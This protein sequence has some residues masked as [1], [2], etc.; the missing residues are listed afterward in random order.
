MPSIGQPHLRCA[1]QMVGGCS[2][3]FLCLGAAFLV[4]FFAFWCLNVVLAAL[5]LLFL[6]DIT[7]AQLLPP[8]APFSTKDDQPGEGQVGCCGDRSA[9]EGGRGAADDDDLGI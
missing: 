7:S 8:A 9:D 3:I 2:G 4:F 1:K 5:S 6:S